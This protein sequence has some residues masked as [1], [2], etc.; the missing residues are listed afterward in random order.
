MYARYFQ[1]RRLLFNSKNI[2]TGDELRLFTVGP[3]A[4]YPEVLN[5]MSMQMISHRSKEYREIHYDTVDRLKE[6]IETDNPIYL[7]TSTGTG[8][9]EASFGSW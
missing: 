6:F 3:V 4:C 8:F 7:F 1:R 5:S 2:R 9:M